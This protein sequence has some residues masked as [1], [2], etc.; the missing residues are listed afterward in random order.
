MG[1]LLLFRPLT[2]RFRIHNTLSTS[3]GRGTSQSTRNMLCPKLAKLCH[4]VRV[5]ENQE[6]IKGAH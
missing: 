6:Q 1:L 4:A 2:C 3:Q 5:F